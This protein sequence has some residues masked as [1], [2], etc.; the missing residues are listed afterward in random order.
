MGRLLRPSGMPGA[1]SLGVY[2]GFRG[3]RGLGFRGSGFRGL[4]AATY[5]NL[6]FLWVLTR[7]PNIIWM[8]W[9]PT[10]N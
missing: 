6:L 9:G 3:L 5:Q 2:L 8:F 4:G 7:N 10:E 1:E